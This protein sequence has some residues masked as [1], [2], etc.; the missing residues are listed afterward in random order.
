[1]SGLGQAINGEGPAAVVVHAPSQSKK[2]SGGSG[3]GGGG[4]CLA[5]VAALAAV[6]LSIWIGLA[7]RA[8][9]AGALDAAPKWS[10]PAAS[11]AGDAPAPP[12]QPTALRRQ[13]GSRSGS[14]SPPADKIG[15][16]PKWVGGAS[17]HSELAAFANLGAPPPPP[18]NATRYSCNTTV[19]GTCVVNKTGIYNISEA[20]CVTKCSKTP[21]P[22]PE[23]EPEP[24]K[25]PEPEPE[26]PKPPEP[27]PEPPKP[28]EP[29]PEPPEPAPEPVAVSSGRALTYSAACGQNRPW[30]R[31]RAADLTARLLLTSKLG[32]T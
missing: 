15:R 19:P 26:P 28:P 8:A 12:A 4:S 21:E 2:P 31:L 1:M 3:G 30:I 27:E 13:P 18:A 10:C 6:G 20:D 17:K 24:P 16:A 32:A 22:E 7:A 9:G 23:P 14:H 25:P 29:E 11:A 5:L